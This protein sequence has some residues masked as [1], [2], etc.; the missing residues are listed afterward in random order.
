MGWVVGAVVFAVLAVGVAVVG[1]SVVRRQGGFEP[2]SE[3]EIEAEDEQ[4]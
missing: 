3:E 4:P 2:M 1:W